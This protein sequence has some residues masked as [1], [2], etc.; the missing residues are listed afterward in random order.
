MSVT[1]EVGLLSGKT[2]TVQ[3]GLDETVETLKRR[4]QMA[5]GVGKGRLLDSRGGILD[6]CVPIRDARVQNGDSLTLHISPVRVCSSL[7]AFTATLGDGSV[8][9]WGDA[10]R[11]VFA[12]KF[13]RGFVTYSA[14]RD[15]LKTVQQ[16]Q[17]S[18]DAFAAILHDG[19]VVTWGDVDFGGDSSA[20]QDQLK[21]V[22][23][24]Q[25]AQNAFAAILGDGSVVTWGEADSGGDSSDMRDQ[26]TNV[27]Q[28]QAS[29]GA[30]AAIL[31]DG[32][33]V[34]WGHAVFG[35]DSS[36]VQDQLKDVQQIQANDHAFA[37]ILG[38]ASVV[39]WGYAGRGGDSSSV[40][41]RLRNVQHI[42]AADWAF[43]ALLDDGS[44]VTWGDD[45]SGGDCS[46]VQEQLT[47]VQ[48]IQ[49]T[50]Y[51]FAAL[52]GD[53][54]VVTWGDA[55]K[56]GDSGAVQDRLK[57]VQQI[58]ATAFA[59][60]AILGDG[61][62]VTWG[63]AD[64]GGDSSAV[65]GQLMNVQHIQTSGSAFAAILGDGSLQQFCCHSGDGS[66][67]TWGDAGACS[68]AVQHQL[69]STPLAA[70]MILCGLVVT[71]RHFSAFLR[72]LDAELTHIGQ[73][74]LYYLVVIN[75]FLASLQ[76]SDLHRASCSL[77]HCLLGAFSILAASR[78]IHFMAG[79]SRK[80]AKV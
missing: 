53:G 22:Q 18:A 5:L 4:A 13:G 9:T 49:A 38:N 75:I 21:N 25:A 54:S 6:G 14:V 58:Q 66:V 34:T 40:Q 71:L 52:L 33:V 31:G 44:V 30:F 24:I 39:T 20:V 32:S 43:A 26:L 78:F 36:A 74:L 55:S 63:E 29:N 80:A 56:G 35:S 67:V 2:A 15:Q 41:E 16:I 73:N 19:S 47:N 12:A 23:R 11:E 46:D 1:V 62:V 64:F 50:G 27:R 7:T 51:A 61:S 42:Q 10:R 57:N 45:A 77:C 76:R 68:S 70:L 59:F 60:A 17:A 72:W 28:I 3:A 65:Q 8:V 37:A 69:K 79:Q 48:Y